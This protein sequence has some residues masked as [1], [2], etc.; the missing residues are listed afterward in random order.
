MAST[1]HG[2]KVEQ[3][4]KNYRGHFLNIQYQFQKKKLL[5]KCMTVRFLFF[6]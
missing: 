5:N 3:N 2:S 4:T 1:G 6:G